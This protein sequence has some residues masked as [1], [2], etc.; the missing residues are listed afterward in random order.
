MRNLLPRFQKMGR[1]ILVRHGARTPIANAP[2]KAR[3]A[4]ALGDWGDARLDGR[5][6][7]VGGAQAHELGWHLGRDLRPDVVH[8]AWSPEASGRCAHSAAAIATGIREAAPRA[9]VV[10]LNDS[11]GDAAASALLR[12]HHGQ[13]RPSRVRVEGDVAGVRRALAKHFPGALPRG[14]PDDKVARVLK[15]IETTHD[16]AEEGG[17]LRPDVDLAPF[18]RDAGEAGVVSIVPRAWATRASEALVAFVRA[19][20]ARP[21]L[22][23]LVCHDNTIVNFLVALGR[24]PTAVPFCGYVVVGG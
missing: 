19:C 12:G 6:T 14:A 3:I 8:L 13:P 2:W 5:L 10:A 4:H 15:F 23:V 21:G 18:W 1:V 11:M 22:Y 24:P 20:T 9:A 17:V 7:D 16:A